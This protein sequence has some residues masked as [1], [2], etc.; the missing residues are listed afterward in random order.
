MGKTLEASL[1]CKRLYG[2]RIVSAASA[3]AAALSICYLYFGSKSVRPLPQDPN[4]A[5]GR[6]AAE[7]AP[8][9]ILPSPIEGEYVG[10]F[11]FVH[12]GSQNVALTGEDA[13]K[14]AKFRPANIRYQYMAGG[15]WEDV[16]T[17]TEGLSRQYGIPSG[18][19][20]EFVIDLDVYSDIGRPFTARVGLEEGSI[21]SQPFDLDIEK[22][23]ICGR[24]SAARKAHFGKLRHSLETAGF[25]S[26]LLDSESFYTNLMLSLAE[27]L[28][29]LSRADDNDSFTGELFRVP[30]LVNGKVYIDYDGRASSDRQRT[31]RARLILDTSR[32]CR[33]WLVDNSNGM[34]LTGEAT[35]DSFIFTFTD[36]LK[37]SESG[38]V[39]EMEIIF[40]SNFGVAIPG[41]HTMSG[42]REQMIADLMKCLSD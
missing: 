25:K 10:R 39:V 26:E 12:H 29:N 34:Y 11:K 17:F 9:E 36:K 22:D 24:F 16:R 19:E 15:I 27:R 6:A 28:S 33:R 3:L 18:V 40:S 14:D 42:I 35:N 32:F 20:H 13:P 31:F 4:L 7:F 8:V 37:F 23:R 2:F 21:W 38:T 41:E 1:Q 30:V 5:L